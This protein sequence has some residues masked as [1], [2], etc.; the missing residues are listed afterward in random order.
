MGNVI[1]QELSQR[2]WL[3][4]EGVAD[5]ESL[6]LFHWSEMKIYFMAKALLGALEP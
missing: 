3:E 6:H 1:D 4:E 5:T 2:P